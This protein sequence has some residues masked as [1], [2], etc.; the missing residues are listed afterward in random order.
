LKFVPV[1]LDSV[2]VVETFI[3]E[4]RDG[5][6]SYGPELVSGVGFTV[7]DR[8]GGA[9]RICGSGKTCEGVVI[10]DHDLLSRSEWS[11]TR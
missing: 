11:G 7:L 8:D 10:W 9:V 2:G 1:G 4:D 3:A 6:T 5:R